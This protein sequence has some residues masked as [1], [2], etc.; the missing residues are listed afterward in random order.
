MRIYGLFT[1]FLWN[2]VCGSCD[3]KSDAPDADG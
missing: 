1:S 2:M 3:G